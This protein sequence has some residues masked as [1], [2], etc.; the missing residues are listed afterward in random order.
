MSIQLRSLDGAQHREAW[1]PTI[2]AMSLEEGAPTQ[3]PHLCS[4]KGLAA[5]QA[6]PRSPSQ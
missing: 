5:L 3:L 6:K 1:E 2:Y 4:V